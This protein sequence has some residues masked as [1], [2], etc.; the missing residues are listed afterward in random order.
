M[1]FTTVS[2]MNL[3][4]SAFAP[5]HISTGNIPERDRVAIWREVIGRKIVRVDIEPLEDHPFHVD[6][7]LFAL[8]GLGLMSAAMSEFR[9]ERSRELVADGNNEFRLVV[10]ISGAETVV[11]N[12]KEVT[13]GVGDAVLVSMAETGGI[14]RSSPGQRVGFNIPYNTLA[15]L[16]S[17]VEAARMRRIGCE[18]PA[19]RLLMSYIGVLQN[20]GAVA[21]PE[22]R[23]L[24]VSHINDLV[25]LAVGATR[26]A[27][28]IARC[29]GLRAAQLHAIM[30]DITENIGRSELSIDAIARR[31]QL[32]TRYIQRMFEADGT[33]FSEFVMGQR[34]SRALRML[35]DPRLADQ[36]IAD[37]AE[38]CGF[39]DPSYFDRRFRRIYGVTPSD[40]RARRQKM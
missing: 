17:D 30:R 2:A 7:S 28:V 38:V 32:G 8:P 1:P 40:I 36:R 35:A 31:H 33:T 20:E 16:I 29:Y 5:L 23:R 12:G 19:L 39:S 13:L 3:S 21:T 18:T 14:V 4:N 26:D 24:V 34:L 37:I 22:L 9:L 11:Q 10:N 15:P 6:A 25:A 27:E